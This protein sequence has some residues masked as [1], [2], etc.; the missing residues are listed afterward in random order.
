M[1]N[2]WVGVA[3]SVVLG[4]AI[5]ECGE[6]S[7]WLAR[8]LVRWAAG[9][10]YPGRAEELEALVDER[11]GKLFKLFTALGFAG[12]A[13]THRVG[14]CLSRPDPAAGLGLVDHLRATA[15]SGPLAGLIW[16]LLYV[17]VPER[18]LALS[19]A[20]APALIWGVLTA[21]V[22]SAVPP[23]RLGVALGFF[24][25]LV[26]AV[27]VACWV[28]APEPWFWGLLVIAP[29][30]LARRLTRLRAG[31]SRRAVGVVLLALSAVGVGSGPLWLSTRLEPR[32]PVVVFAV[33]ITVGVGFGMAVGIGR[34]V[35][36]AARPERTAGEA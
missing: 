26:G 22:L 36:G 30:P 33:L 18:S 5:N 11:P 2:G 31:T 3:L 28:T 27:A 1:V 6:L 15:V 7:P 13:A 25:C 16:M 24:A 21:A 19:E 14:R 20:V 32:A 8:R 34:T 9:V 23:V 10:R 12:A 4:L 29:A 17:A 35:F